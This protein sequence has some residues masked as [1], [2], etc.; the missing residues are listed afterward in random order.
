MVEAGGRAR[1]P[2]FPA[3]CT[4]QVFDLDL[5]G[6]PKSEREALSFILDELGW[7][8]YLGFIQVTGDT[9]HIGCS[10]SAREFFAQVFQEASEAAQ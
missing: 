1:G 3:H 7:D 9:L 4:G 5:S 10:P 8:G 6:M 2:E